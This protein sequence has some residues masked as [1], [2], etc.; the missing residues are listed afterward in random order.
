MHAL[1]QFLL[2][3]DHR[4]F[5]KRKYRLCLVHNYELHGYQPRHPSLRK[6]NNPL[7]V[8]E[9]DLPCVPG[10]CAAV[11]IELDELSAEDASTCLLRVNRR[12]RP[13]RYGEVRCHWKNALLVSVALQQDKTDMRT[14]QCIAAFHGGVVPADGGG[15]SSIMDSRIP[16]AF[17][18][19]H[20]APA[21]DDGRPDDS[22]PCPVFVTGR[23]RRKVRSSR[24]FPIATAQTRP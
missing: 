21:G 19:R 5:F 22:S 7:F 24:R 17:T 1:D 18:Q 3:A 14:L 20:M 15:R 9:R 10:A 4:Y 6:P 16:D 8:D 11:S 23:V 13:E 2:A 12:D